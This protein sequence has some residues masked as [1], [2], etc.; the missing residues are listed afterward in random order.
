MAYL[1]LGAL[2]EYGAGALGIFPNLVVFQFNPEQLSRT[3]NIPPDSGG[4]QRK[5]EPSQASAPPSESVQITA[6]FS[7]ADDLGKRGAAAERAREFGISPQLAA[8]ERMVFPKGGLISSLVGAAV[9]AVGA[10]IAGDGKGPATR[11]TPREQLPRILFVW[12]RSRVV[13]V[14]IRS[15]TITEQKFDARLNPVQAEVQV[16]LDVISFAPDS[17]DVVGIGALTYTQTVKDA[18]VA[19][20]LAQTAPLAADIIPF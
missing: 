8:L 16:G 3:L 7:A 15:L 2:V 12:G 20:H 14:K 19:L 11:A 10:T 17:D 4:E 13:P 5:R 6:H 18:R 1:V 9:D